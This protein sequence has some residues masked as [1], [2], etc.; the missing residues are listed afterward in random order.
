MQR[1]VLGA[2]PVL[3]VE[4]E[5]RHDLGRDEGVAQPLPDILHRLIGGVQHIC[6]IEAIVAQFIVDELIGREITRARH[7]AGGEE[8]CGLRELGT[9][10]A[11]F[12]IANGADG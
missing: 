12:A 3:V 8:Q 6:L 2:E 11:V 5:L 4:L 10:I 7:L 1:A 9:M